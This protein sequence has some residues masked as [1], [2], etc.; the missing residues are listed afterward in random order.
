MHC[1]NYLK[2]TAGRDAFLR[3]YLLRT[4]VKLR[5]AFR[6]GNRNRSSSLRNTQTLFTARTVV[7]LMCLTILKLAF[8]CSPFILNRIDFSHEHRILL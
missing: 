1:S 4:L 6:A 3:Q 7:I 2:K 5:F 8:L